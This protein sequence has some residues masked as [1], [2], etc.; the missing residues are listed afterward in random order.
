[1]KKSTQALLA[2]ALLSA[3]SGASMMGATPAEAAPQIRKTCDYKLATP[4]LPE[5]TCRDQGH[6]TKHLGGPYTS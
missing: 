1:M 5:D 3:V 2:T 6:T 4:R